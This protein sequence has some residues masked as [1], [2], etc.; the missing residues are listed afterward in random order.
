MLPAV[1]AYL[2]LVSKRDQRKY[3]DRLIPDA[4]AR[5]ILDAGRLTGS[6]ANRQP[7][8][9][10]VIEDRD[11]LRRLAEMVY[12]PDNLLDAGLVVVITQ[13]GKGPGQFDAGRAAQN[14]MLAA[15][16]EGVVSCPNGVKDS[17][18][19]AELLGLAEEE[20]PVIV[21]SFGYPARERDPEARSPE[22]WIEHVNRKS[23]DEVVQRL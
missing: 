12:V 16:N 6:A 20:Q 8:R 9:F 2:A 22:E 5:R 21:L 13:Q 19:A 18:A 7:W 3:A 15:W 14:M 17:K 1:D 23:F 11:L 4:V 10:L